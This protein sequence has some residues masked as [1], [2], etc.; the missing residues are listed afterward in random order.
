MNKNVLALAYLGDSIY[1]VYVRKYLLDQNIEKVSV[2]QKEATN[3]VSARCQGKFL[4]DMIETNFFNEEELEIIKRGRNHKSRN[5]RH[6]DIQTYHNA[7]GLET[8]IGYLYLEGNTKRIEE[9]MKY[10]LG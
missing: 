10:I 2:L 6:V 8:L 4:L 7:T 5:P 9:I 3:Y 1:E